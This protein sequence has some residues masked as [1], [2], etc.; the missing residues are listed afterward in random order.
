MLP[1]T[2]KCPV[3][4]VTEIQ[5][6]VGSRCP[7]KSQA[8]YLNAQFVKVLIQFE[9][10]ANAIR[11]LKGTGT[12]TRISPNAWQI[13]PICIVSTKIIRTP[14]LI[15]QLI[16]RRFHKWHRVYSHLQRR[17]PEISKNL[18]CHFTNWLRPFRLQQPNPVHIRLHYLLMIFL[19]LMRRPTSFFISGRLLGT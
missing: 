19:T 4:S 14:S 6:I 7:V 5:S 12:N 1:Q 9:H 16:E 8:D 10:P 17:G 2:I 11:F 15:D 3:Y 18:R 13:A